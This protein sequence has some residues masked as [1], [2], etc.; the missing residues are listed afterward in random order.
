[1]IEPYEVW[2]LIDALELEAGLSSLLEAQMNGVD[3]EGVASE[4]DM[5]NDQAQTV[6]EL[7]EKEC[8]G[9]ML[10]ASALMLV[11]G[12]LCPEAVRCDMTT[13][14]EVSTHPICI[15]GIIRDAKWKRRGRS[16]HGRN[17][18]ATG[19]GVSAITPRSACQGCL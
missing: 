4:P 1:M 9:S 2:R 13:L 18:G 12:L 8:L 10:A 17:A 16:E 7:L 14:P 15:D 19:S 11:E 5:G 6:P 3:A